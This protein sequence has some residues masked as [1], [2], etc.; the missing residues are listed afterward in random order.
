VRRRLRVGSLLAALAVVWLVTAGPSVATPDAPRHPAVTAAAPKAGW[1]SS[2]NLGHHLPT[3]PI[4]PDVS[5][6]QL[7]VEGSN[8]I[9][10]V[11][12]V[13]TA[14]TSSEAVAAIRWPIPAGSRATTVSLPIAGSAP[15]AVSVEA[16]RITGNFAVAYGGPYSAVPA[17]T[18]AHAVGGTLDGNRLAFDN[19][20]TLARG[21]QLSVLLVPGPLDKLVLAPPTAAAL[22]LATIQVSHHRRH[23][24]TRHHRGGSTHHH[25]GTRGHRHPGS[26][27]PGGAGP[28]KLPPVKAS[29]G[30]LPSGGGSAPVVAGST[31]PSP[32]PAALKEPATALP[33]WRRIVAV[34][35]IAA[36]VLVFLAT[37]RRPQPA[38]GEHAAGS[39]GIGRFVADRATPPVHL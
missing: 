7:A 37:R 31:T 22:K 29:H 17:Y 6:H 19:I 30:G 39:R 38:G 26:T 21:G 12:G 35:V 4:N 18:C 32:A 20:G 23:H 27:P 24:T 5:G 3:L 9:P 14:P 2:A 13:S 11:V 28:S 25:Q 36:E 15:P 1:W 33:R 10:A 34:A 16:C 8:A